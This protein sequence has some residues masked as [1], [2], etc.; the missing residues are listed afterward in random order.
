LRRQQL[1]P[2][3]HTSCGGVEGDVA[4]QVGGVR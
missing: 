1:R 4:G 3:A 2:R